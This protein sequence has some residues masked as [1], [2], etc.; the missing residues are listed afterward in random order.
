MGTAYAVG[1]AINHGE[2]LISRI[3]TVTGKDVAHA[4]NFETLFGTPISELLA[5]AETQ[6]N[7]D[8]PF[9]LGGPMM[10]FNLSGDNLPVT[11]TANCIL[12]GVDEAAPKT[13]P[14]PCIRCGECA[15]ACP[16]SLLPQQIYWHARDKDFD[17]TQDYNLFDCIECGCC[18]YVCP[19]K[20]PLVSYFRF[21]K[22]EIMNQE[23]ERKKSDQA[24]ER[25]ET[26]QVRLDRE[27]REKE[28]RQKQRKAALAASKAKKAAEEKAAAAIEEKENG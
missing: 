4:G 11:K 20:I 14:L 5:F 12:V 27:Q 1:R 2:P 9:I 26:R 10:G 8:E 22:T 15:D 23:R 21:A 24:R 6:R 3:V 18:D 7:A 28:E 17:K 19:S 13:E 25:F 16:A